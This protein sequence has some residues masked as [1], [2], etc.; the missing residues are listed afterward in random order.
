MGSGMGKTLADEVS[1]GEY[2]FVLGLKY[3]C[4]RGRVDTE[5]APG[6]SVGKVMGEDLSISD[7]AGDDAKAFTSKAE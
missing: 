4:S 7:M 5:G 2:D 3:G 1:T 6:S